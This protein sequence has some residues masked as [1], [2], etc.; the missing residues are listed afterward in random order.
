MTATMP[1]K[2]TDT[3]RVSIAR[4]ALF[5]ALSQ[6][7]LV[8]NRGK[9][10]L[11]VLGCVRIA[12]DGEALRLTT[13]DFDRTISA[14]VLADG[15]ADFPTLVVP[16]HRLLAIVGQLPEGTVNIA[17]RRHGIR[18]TA[19]RAKF[20]LAGMPADEFPSMP[21]DGERVT[22]VSIAAGALL[23]ALPR[24]AAFCSNA[25]KRPVFAGVHIKAPKD[26]PLYLEATDGNQLAR[27]WIER[28]S[29]P[30]LDIIIPAASVAVAAK[31]FADASTLTL[32]LSERRA[33]FTSDDSTRLETALME[34]PYPNTAQVINADAPHTVTV[35]RL[36]LLGAVK[37][38][39]A[40]AANE[41]LFQIALEWHTDHVVV[42]GVGD[43]DS[44][45]SEDVV[46][47]TMTSGDP[48]RIAFGTR[49]IIQALSVRTADV[50]RINLKGP[51]RAMMLRDDG[52][53]DVQNMVMPRRELR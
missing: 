36:A 51:E 10:S 42:L 48:L 33:V 37:R 34:G 32:G 41:N 40:V 26:G 53:K 16:C 8:A 24:L 47:C 3:A 14:S 31:L 1:D 28:T 39:A 19:G 43:T 44:G 35:D 20:E 30:A 4:S 7:A 46:P 23:E 50:I 17:P 38:V 18:L 9:P 12:A 11:P 52:F 45:T 25:E 21:S 5:D 13:T 15:A 6:V 22:S 2:G 29:G 49:Y 27:E